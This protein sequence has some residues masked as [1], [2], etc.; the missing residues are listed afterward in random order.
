M[1]K[2]TDTY[3]PAPGLVVAVC[4]SRTARR[5]FVE[6]YGASRVEGQ[7]AGAPDVRVEIGFAARLPADVPAGGHKTVRWAVAVGPLGGPL[8]SRVVLAGA[9]RSFGLSLVQGFVVEPLV[10]IASP[11]AGHVL[12]PAAALADEDGAIVVLGRS[13]SGKTSVVAR[14]LA[15]GHLALGDDQVLIDASGAVR[16]WPRRLRVYP[17]LRFTAP[18][19]VGA[20][21]ARK[22]MRLTALAAAA[23]AS[24][25]WVAPSLP[26]SYGDVGGEAAAGPIP[27]RRIV[28]V[29][30]GGSA[31][32]LS[33]SALEA[34]SVGDI[35][36]E[37]LRQQRSRLRAVMG[38]EADAV[39]LTVEEQEAAIL[40][41]ALSN[42][43]AEVW[44]VPQDWPAPL[45]VRA[46]AD[47]L[48]LRS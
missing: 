9:P 42:I 16:S 22:R 38:A 19:A 26:L 36:R 45:A 46:L 18:A 32:K 5:H 4:G 33:A 12:L 40:S 23:R 43:S 10:S 41:Q 2:T 48:E 3:S 27:V 28:V 24:G 39:L 29:Q 7:E 37:V 44:T 6:E 25:G 1:T 11:R 20:L 17:D 15:A 31:A 8:T 35:A 13:R 34:S 21:P 14:A 47:R 30:R